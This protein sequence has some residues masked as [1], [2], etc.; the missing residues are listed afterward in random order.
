MRRDER[1]TVE[2]HARVDLELTAGSI[3]VRAAEAG[4]ITVSIEAGS[5]NDLEV[6]QM[7]DAISVRQGRRSRNARVV[8]DVPVGTDVSVKGVSVQVSARGALG[9]L[10]SK[11]ASGDVDVDDV[12]RLDLA[13]SS[14]D[15]RIGIVRDEATFT[16]TSGDIVVRSVGGRLTASLTSGD[17]RVDHASGDV[18]AGTASGDITVSRC[19]GSA[20]GIR[21]VSG[22]IRVGLPTGIRVDPDIATMSGRVH[23]PEPARADPSGGLSAVRRPVALRLRSVSG[24]IR[25][26]RAD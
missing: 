8:V 1:F 16:T 7:G 2:G 26:T 24:D 9:W 18:D 6:S 4:S 17:I 14:G 11:T 21:T 3:T 25:V 23:L 19:D 20:I 5:A 15:A 13:M 12:V 10:R 22:D